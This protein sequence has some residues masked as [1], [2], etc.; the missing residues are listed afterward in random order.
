MHSIPQDQTEQSK[1][2]REEDLKSLII[3]F[4]THSHMMKHVKLSLDSCTISVNE[5]AAMEALY[6][7]GNLTTGELIDLVLIPN[8]SM[9]Y[10]LGTLQEKGY[11]IREKDDV[12]KRI[13]RLSLSDSGRRLFRDIYAAHFEHM[14]TIFNV[15]TEEEETEMQ[16]ILKKLGKHAER[17]ADETHKN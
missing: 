14:R 13:Q 16:R 11:I 8:S 7:K 1:P 5:F 15:L 10:V 17:Q 2:V 4:K 9:T 3:L 12:D 6:S